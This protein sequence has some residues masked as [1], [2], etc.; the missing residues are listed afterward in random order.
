[1]TN[2]IQVPSLAITTTDGGSTVTVATDGTA[3]GPTETRTVTTGLTSAATTEITSGLQG[4]RAGRHHDHRRSRGGFAAPARAGSGAGGFPGGGD[5][6]GF[7][8]G[9]GRTG[10]GGATP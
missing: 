1:M 7:G 9:T 5:F 10:A 6:G 8:G 2:V 4:R 3:N